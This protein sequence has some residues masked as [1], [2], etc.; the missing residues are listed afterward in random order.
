M[1]ECADPT[2]ID[3]ILNVSMNNP[4]LYDKSEAGYINKAAKKCK[5]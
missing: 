3:V 1:A 5:T 4:E 2:I